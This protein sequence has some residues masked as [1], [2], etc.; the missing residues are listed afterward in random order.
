MRLAFCL[1]DM[2]Y[3]SGLK[4]PTLPYSEL[5]CIEY[6][7]S[8][9]YVSLCEITVGNWQGS[10]LYLEFNSTRLVKRNIDILYTN[11]LLRRLNELLGLNGSREWWDR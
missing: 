4:G 1:F 3:E 6:Y 8:E 2:H 7:P 11:R 10:L 9:S 5:D